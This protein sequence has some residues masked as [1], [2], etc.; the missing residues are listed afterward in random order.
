LK[1]REFIALLGRAARRG[2]SLRAHSNRTWQPLAFWCVVLP[3]GIRSEFEPNVFL[4]DVTAALFISW[5]WFSGS[6]G[7]PW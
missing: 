5:P 1:R 4:V 6:A 2:R 7:S 3:V